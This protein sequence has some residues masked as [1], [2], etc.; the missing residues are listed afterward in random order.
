MSP[1]DVTANLADAMF[2]RL[3]PGP[4][5]QNAGLTPG[6]TPEQ[7]LEQRVAAIEGVLEQALRWLAHEALSAKIRQLEAE[8]K[9]LKAQLKGRPR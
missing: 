7:T 4:Q 5:P 9:N 6:Y 2:G 1:H 8:N 3:R